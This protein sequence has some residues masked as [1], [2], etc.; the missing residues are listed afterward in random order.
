MLTGAASA[1][2]PPVA[3]AG[4]PYAGMAGTSVNF[5]GSG[6]TDPQWQALT[7]AWNFGDGSA[8]VSGS[9][10]GA[11]ACEVPWLTP[12]AASVFHSY[13]YGGVYSVTLTVRDVGGNIASVSGGVVLT[14]T[15]STAGAFTGQV[16]T[17]PVA[18]TSTSGSGVGTTT[19]NLSYGLGAVSVANSGNYSVVPTGSTVTDSASGTGASIGAPTLGGNG[20]PVA[21][22]VPSSG[23]A[24]FGA[25]VTPGFDCRAN[26]PAALKTSLGFT[27]LLE[28]HAEAHGGYDL[29]S[30]VLLALHDKTRS[31]E[32]VPW[33]PE[34]ASAGRQRRRSTVFKVGGV[35]F[36]LTVLLDKALKGF[37]GKHGF[38]N[39][40][41]V[42][43]RKD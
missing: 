29:I 17:N 28:Q 23:P 1:G 31:G 4:G 24:T 9:A 27:V 33:Q 43:A 19:W 15:V 20:N 22:F 10:P 38:A 16:A 25:F 41:R 6:S 39:A 42:V 14:A 37:V 30:A 35:F 32:D 21:V 2:A 5:S 40:Y 8:P 13:Q 7:Y 36:L 18:Q 11:P 3:N 26:V 34:P 12:C